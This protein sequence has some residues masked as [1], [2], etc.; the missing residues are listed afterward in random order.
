MNLITDP[1]IPVIRLNNSTDTICPWQIAEKDNPVMEINAP[2]PD[3]QGALYQFLIGLIQTCF[4]PEEENDWSYFWEKMPEEKELQE[5]FNGA[6][7]NFEI[8]NNTGPAFMQDF[9]LPDGS[10]KDISTLLIDIPGENTIKHNLDHFNKRGQIRHL[11]ASCTATALYTL[12]TNAPSGGSG[13][14]VG[15]RGGGPLTT[16]LIP[17]KAKETIWKRLWPNILPEEEFASVRSI[18]G[19]ILPWL[20]ESRISDKGQITV[21]GD[22]HDL[23]M[24]WGMPRRI[25]LGANVGY[26]KCDLCGSYSQDRYDDYRTKNY[27]TNYN[28]AWVHP[29]TPYHFDPKKKNPPLSLKGQQGG[30]G[31]RH[32][33][34]LVLQDEEKDNKAA[35]TVRF[36]QEERLHSLGVNY[37]LSLWCFGYDMDNMKARCWYDNHFPIL[38]ISPRK[39]RNLIGWADELI[40][41]ARSVVFILRS[42]IKSAWF[43]R[44]TEIQGDMSM[45][46]SEFWHATEPGFYSLL[47]KLADLPEETE[48]APPEI[49]HNW[50]KILEKCVF[51]LFEKSTLNS[52]QE[53]VNL[54]RI[55]LAN[56]DLK[57]KFYG[58]K[59]IKNLRI[60]ATEE[61]DK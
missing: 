15:L 9:A 44:P 21:P 8:E 55:I 31:Y 26:G 28:G 1:W 7:E 11:C 29:L 20:T 10:S 60:K 2:R 59:E 37:S 57:K 43:K 58:N 45:I 41:S 50:F 32:W 5:S 18:D 35:T 36:F 23:Q 17:A 14:R 34:S 24:Y 33:L 47:Y 3:F 19:S 38:S 54:K 12:Q 27:G 22:V 39:Q 16:L 53:D 48:M 4:A 49:Y 56:R 51:A 13:H 40:S 30:L 46:D 6:Q 52:T 25:R 61:T 42:S